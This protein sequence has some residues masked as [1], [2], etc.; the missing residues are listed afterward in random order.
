[1]KISDSIVQEKRLTETAF[2]VL[3]LSVD[4]RIKYIRTPKWFNYKVASQ[5]L[6]KM[7]DLLT[8]PKCDR[9]PN[10][11]VAGDTNHGKTSLVRKFLSRYPPYDNPDGG[12]IQL[13]IL[14]M[15][16]PPSPDEG[17]FYGAILDRLCTPYRESDSKIKKEKEALRVMTTVGVRMLI[18]D[19]FHHLIAG[20]LTRQQAQLNAIK[21][22][23]AQLQIPIVAAGTKEAFSAIRVDP[24]MA[25]RFRSTFLDRWQ[26][27]KNFA[28][29]LKTFEKTLP[30]K[31][32]SCLMDKELLNEI[33]YMSE[34]V[35]GEVSEIVRD[36]AVL[37]LRSGREKITKDILKGLNWERPSSRSGKISSGAKNR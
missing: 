22:L 12:A 17:R 19:D 20:A 2:S 30:L 24:Q 11:L 33:H 18:I 31:E 32:P 5:T 1:M 8:Y 29:L 34:G 7:E 36:A 6:D 27:D 23:G 35:L 10:L 4:D 21:N 14:Y 9:M 16:A 26:A 3:D 28:S 13:P 25:N 15:L 37:A